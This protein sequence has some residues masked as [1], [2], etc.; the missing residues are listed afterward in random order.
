MFMSDS[1]T[2]PNDFKEIPCI[3]ETTTLITEVKCVL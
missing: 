1:L 3:N 2:F